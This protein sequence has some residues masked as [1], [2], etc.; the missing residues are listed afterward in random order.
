MS[1][2]LTC[3][4]YKIK[5]V[6]SLP[7]IRNTLKLSMS[8]VVLMFLPLLVTP[9]LSRLYLPSDYGAWGVFSSVLSIVTAFVFLSYEN[10]IVKSTSQKELPN[11]YVLCLIISLIIIGVITFIFWGGFILGYSFFVDF[12]SISLLVIVLLTTAL[13]NLNTNLANNQK[14]YSIMAVSNVI[15]GLI[16]AGSRI[17]L[18]LFPFIAYGLIVGNAISHIFG[19]FFLFIC[20]RGVFNKAFFQTVNF[21]EV[22]RLA[23]KYKKFPFYD[24]P[25]RFIEFTVGNFAL[26]ILSFFWSH[27]D[28]GC[29]SM[30]VQFVLMPISII[31]SAM[32]NVYYREISEATTEV[33]VSSVTI[34]AA[35]ITFALSCLPLLFLALGGDQ[36]LVYFLGAR[37]S[38]VAPMSLCMCVFSV[39]VILSEPLLAIFRALDKQEDRF[40]LNVMCLILSLGGLIISAIITGNIYISVIIYAT[41]YG[42][43]RYLMYLRELQ[44]AGVFLKDI[45]HHFIV[46]SIICYSILAVRLIF[47][48]DLI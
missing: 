10:T 22:K 33:E 18:G 40:K 11:L 39:P 12:P 4:F 43:V 28:I 37:W 9:I 1:Y 7:F 35:K 13:Y 16:Q 42:F 46:I 21:K 34:K 3:L 15:N 23:V 38:N 19:V 36:L 47:T 31:G 24:A 20:L 45:S 41:L 44:I 25:A 26:I 48:F 14:K 5:Q 2:N 17:I 8:S 32:G 27:E 6:Y 30:V 29:F